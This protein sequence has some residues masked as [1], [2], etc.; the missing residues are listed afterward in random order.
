VGSSAEHWNG[1]NWNAWTFP[2]I[3]AMNGGNP[4]A[5]ISCASATECVAVGAGLIATWN[6]SSWTVNAQFVNHGIGFNAVSCATTSACV[7]IDGENTL[8]SYGWD[9]SSWSIQSKFWAPAG[10]GSLTVNSV[11]C[12][13]PMTCIAVGSYGPQPGPFAMIAER[14]Q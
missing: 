8:A 13:A 14:Y 3:D 1:T 5:G 6:G 4:L 9:G 7:A 12:V 10:P 2:Q 11:S